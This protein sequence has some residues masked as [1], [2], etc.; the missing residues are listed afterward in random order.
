MEKSEE[1]LHKLLQVVIQS[2]A[3]DV[4][5]KVGSPPLFRINGV[6]TEM[7]AAKL[8]PEFVQAFVKLLI[9]N[10]AVRDRLDE[11][12]DYDLSYSIPGLARFRANIFRQRGT[13]AAILRVIPWKIPTVEELGLPPIVE[14]LAMEDRGLILVTGPTGSGKSTTLAAMIEVINQEKKVHIVTIE[15]P[16]EF[17]HTDKKSSISQREI[18]TD[19]ANFAGALRAA[20][21]QDPDVILVGEMRDTETI[22]VALK[23][24]ETGHLVLSTLHTTDAMGTVNRLIGVFPAEEQSTVRI[25]LADSLKG[26]IAQRLLPR[27]DGKGRVASVEVMVA[28]STIQGCIREMDK[29]YMIP[30][31]LEEGRSQYGMQ[32]FD[33]HLMELYKAGKITFVVAKAAASRPSDFERAVMLET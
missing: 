22:D 3:S 4:H 16:I 20:L 6:L 2:G 23:A 8:T 10:K 29:T 5:F 1:F 7:K 14:K 17:L 25:R 24:A 11:L 21:R 19:T 33:Q 18:R 31:Y 12:Q 26:I 30:H 27:A 9:T 15:D 13:L 28:T 32:S